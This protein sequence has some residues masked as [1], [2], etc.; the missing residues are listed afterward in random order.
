MTEYK[1]RRCKYEWNSRLKAEKPKTCPKCKSYFWDKARQRN[2]GEE[3][4]MQNIK[5]E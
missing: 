1:C 5:E 2:G 4:F 3:K